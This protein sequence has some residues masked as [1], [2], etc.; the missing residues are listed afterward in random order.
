[1]A[2]QTHLSV[3]EFEP[4]LRGELDEQARARVDAHLA[5]C[6]SC[7]Q[8]WQAYQE[9]ERL[10]DQ[11][12][13]A[14]AAGVVKP[15]T[16]TAPRARSVEPGGGT[17]RQFLKN[18]RASAL[19]EPSQLAEIETWPSAQSGHDRALAQ[20][21]VLKGLLTRFQGERLL[22][23]RT[24]GFFVGPYVV[25]D[26]IGAGGMGQ[27][28]KA[29]HRRMKRTVALKVLPK[30]RR[31][32]PEAQARFREMAQATQ[33]T[34]F[35]ETGADDW[36]AFWDGLARELGQVDL[37]ELRNIDEY[38]EGTEDGQPR[39]FHIDALQQCGFE[40][41]EIYWQESADAVMGAWKPVP[42]EG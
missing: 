39:Q 31:S 24:Q 28:Y 36:H 33:R 9:R 25:T 42:R 37:Q 40:H 6:P 15:P 29:M 27:V 8:Q 32:D 12:R 4:Y 41:V 20:E 14:A 23:G 17:S 7:Q 10:A 21:L 11:Y 2:D 38:W 1:M 16:A 19:L 30:A 18:L 22:A 34:A 5:S 3:D 35:Q 13:A 26:K